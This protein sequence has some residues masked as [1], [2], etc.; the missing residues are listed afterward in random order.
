MPRQLLK[1]VIE[2]MVAI[3][4]KFSVSSN[5]PMILAIWTC[6]SAHLLLQ[7]EVNESAEII[8]LRIRFE[9]N[10][11]Q[12]LRPRMAAWCNQKN[13]SIRCGFFVC[14][15]QDGETLAAYF[16]RIFPSKL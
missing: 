1:E 12:A 7:I 13:W 14:D 3:N 16:R 9:R 10:C 11:P 2:A 15:Q 6:E 8:K 4:W 5:T